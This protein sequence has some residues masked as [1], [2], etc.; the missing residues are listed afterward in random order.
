M[1]KNI[2]KFSLITISI[3]LGFSCK[4][5][6]KSPCG[7]TDITL[8][9]LDKDRTLGLQVD[10]SIKATPAEYTILDSAK[11]PLVYQE[12]NTIKNNFLNSGKVDHSTDFAW[13]LRVLKDDSTLNAFCTPGGYIYVYSALIKY[14]PTLDALAGVMGHEMAHAALRHSTKTMTQQYGLTMLLSIVGGDKSKLAQI[15]VGLKQLKYSRCHE[16]EADSYSVEYL[17]NAKTTS[18]ASVGYQCDATA[19]FFEKIEAAGGS[20]TPEFLSTH[21]S[22]DNRV[23]AIKEKAAS[24]GCNTSTPYDASGSRIQAIVN[25]LK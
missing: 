13:K 24:I 19:R 8:F 18:G 4:K 20:R 23:A 7:I 17:A 22:P 9:S 2:F 21:P 15:V 25:S 10:S 3:L 12:L 14:L 16:S 1:R 5:S 11:Y 6:A